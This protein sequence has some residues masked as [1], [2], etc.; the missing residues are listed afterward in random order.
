MDVRAQI[1]S[2]FHLDK[3]IGCHTCSVACKNVWTDRTG[4]EYMWWNNV[5]TQP[6]TGYPTAWEDQE[7]YQRRLGARTTASSRL[8]ARRRQARRAGQH[9]PQPAACPTLDDYYEPWTYRYERP[10]HGAR[11]ATTSPPRGPISL[12]TG[13]PIDI[14]AGPELGRRPRRLAGLRRATIPN[15]AALTAEERG[16]AVRDRA[17]RLL[18]PAAH[19]QPLPRTR[20]AWRPAR[21]ARSTS[22]ARTASCSSTRTRC[23][24]WRAVRG[25]VPV[26]E[27][28][29]QLDAAASPRSASSATRASRA[30]RRR[31]ASTPASAASATWACCSTTP[32]RI[33][34]AAARARRRARRRAA[35]R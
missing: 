8:Q 3:C 24:G 4:A 27:D 35:R 33:A 15:L 29:L 21:P 26:Q 17:A 25:G 2:V 22:A 12:I 7:R 18:L 31:P 13:K 5:E 30:A 6:G 9:L 23:R 34:E 20:P 11:R 14:E 1:A 10:L 28:L 19:L 32:T 16:A